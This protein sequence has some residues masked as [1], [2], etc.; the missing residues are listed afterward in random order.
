M[1]TTLDE[2]DRPFDRKVDKWDGKDHVPLT[3]PFFLSI[4]PYHPAYAPRAQPH[5]QPLGAELSKDSS[6]VGMLASKISH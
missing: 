5:P 3:I 6:A 1:N 2:R 4:P